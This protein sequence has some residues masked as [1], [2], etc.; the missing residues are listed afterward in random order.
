MSSGSTRRRR[1][2]PASRGSTGRRCA[3]PEGD[4]RGGTETTLIAIQ[5][6][7]YYIGRDEKQQDELRASVAS[8]G[9]DLG[10]NRYLSDCVQELMRLCYPAYVYTRECVRDCTFEGLSSDLSNS[11]RWPVREGTVVWGSQHVTHH[12][13]SVWGEDAEEYRPMRWRSASQAQKDG[14][15]TFVRGPGSARAT[16]SR[17]AR[18]HSSWASSSASSTSST[19]CK[20][21]E[22]RP[23]PDDEAGLSCPRDAQ[24]EAEV[25]PV[26][27]SSSTEPAWVMGSS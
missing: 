25:A 10:S 9:F 14:F 26:A 21:P 18:P 5:R 16:C 20:V 17:G 13:R 8:D 6:S 4:A 15:L 27:M 2:C 1:V 22:L 24:A 12:M 19:W 23:R 7:L 3:R 11:T